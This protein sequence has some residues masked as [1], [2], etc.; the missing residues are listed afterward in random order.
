MQA[1][2]PMPRA[3]TGNAHGWP[4]LADLILANL[5]Y[6]IDWHLYQEEIPAGH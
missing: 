3:F 1:W 2:A 6:L 5:Y 4:P